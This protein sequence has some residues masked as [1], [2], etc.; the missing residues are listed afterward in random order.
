MSSKLMILGNQD[1]SQIIDLSTDEQTC[2]MASFPFDRAN[3]G[4]FL[5]GRPFACDM[6]YCAWYEKLNDTWIRVCL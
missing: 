1:E 3:T 2:K 6:N 5:D 4:I